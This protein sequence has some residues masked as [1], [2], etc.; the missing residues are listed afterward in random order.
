MNKSFLLFLF[1]VSLVGIAFFGCA[2]EAPRTDVTLELTSPDTIEALVEK[3][4]VTVGTSYQD[5]D[6][7]PESTPAQVTYVDS[8]E[9]QKPISVQN[10]YSLYQGDSG[11][12]DQAVVS[13]SNITVWNADSDKTLESLSGEPISV[14][15]PATGDFVPSGEVKE[16]VTTVTTTYTPATSS[17]TLTPRPSSDVSV[18]TTGNGYIYQGNNTPGT[19]YTQS[20]VTSGGSTYTVQ[21]GDNLIKIAKQHGVTVNSICQANGIS[22]TQILRVGQTLVIPGATSSPVTTTTTTVVPANTTASISSV[23]TPISEGVPSAPAS[24]SS[25]GTYTVQAGDSYWKLARQF[26]TSVEA[27]MSLNNTTSDRL[28]IGQ[29]I[30]VPQQ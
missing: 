24:T 25:V 2:K 12:G 29:I 28:R 9:M 26:N 23:V 13:Q 6:N 21:A 3:D 30:R 20:A 15:P 10:D 18:V 14:V 16:T 5:I 11:I 4:L 17:S 22:R 8:V 27:L 7:Q 19:S 1:T